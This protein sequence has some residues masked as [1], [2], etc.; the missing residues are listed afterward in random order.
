MLS[1]MAIFYSFLWQ[2]NISL[3]VCV[4][5]CVYHIFFFNFSID[6]SLGCFHFLTIVNNAAMNIEV[7]ISFLVSVFVFFR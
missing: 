3:C 7:R 1:Q 2:S 6:G 5:V 4:C